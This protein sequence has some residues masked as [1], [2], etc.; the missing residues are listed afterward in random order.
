VYGSRFTGAERRVHLY[1]HQ[2]ANKG[3]T[4]LS[5]VLNDLNLTDMETGYK[6]FRMDLLKTIPI[7][8]KRFGIEPEVTAKL[9]RRRYRVVES[10]IGYNAR[11]YD[12]GKKIGVRDL[13][14]ALYCIVRYGLAD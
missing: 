11:G 4:F 8:S 2:V 3:L 1:F 10:P 5:N 9:A 13:F 14:N 12:E 6:V 7:K